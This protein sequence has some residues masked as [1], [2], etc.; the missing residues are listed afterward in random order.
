MA[1][2]IQP[3]PHRKAGGGGGWLAVPVRETLDPLAPSLLASRTL[4]A[5][6]SLNI[7]STSWKRIWQDLN[8]RGEARGA[9]GASVAPARGRG[10]GVLP[11]GGI[12]QFPLSSTWHQ[13]LHFDSFYFKLSSISLLGKGR[14]EAGEVAVVCRESGDSGAVGK[15]E[16]SWQSCAEFLGIGT[17]HLR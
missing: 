16:A 15:P 3:S 2:V 5:A 13:P 10:A 14:R 7:L 17:G 1:I 4:P 8:I 12:L 9:R 6:C 11:A